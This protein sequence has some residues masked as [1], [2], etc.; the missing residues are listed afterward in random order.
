MEQ[1]LKF[2]EIFI[3]IVKYVFPT[4]ALALSI[5]S[6]KDSRRINKVQTRLIEI[7][8]NLKSMS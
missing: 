2:K 3:G 8:K 7:E 4:I 5:L 6:Y 1:W